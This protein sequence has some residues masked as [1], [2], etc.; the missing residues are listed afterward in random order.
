MAAKGKKIQVTLVKSP[1]GR[2]PVQRRTVR[3]L[4][5]RKVRQTVELP[6]N[7]SVL[8]MVSSVSHLIEVKELD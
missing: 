1:L 6:V 8:G 4:G 7:P 2:K 3:A 5:L